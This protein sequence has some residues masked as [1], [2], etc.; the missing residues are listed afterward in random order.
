MKLHKFFVLAVVLTLL[1]AVTLT[2]VAAGKPAPVTVQI[3]AVY[4]HIRYFSEK[5]AIRVG[6]PDS[7]CAAIQNIGSAII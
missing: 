7:A 6:N 5:T 3:L 2:P 4:K 1:S